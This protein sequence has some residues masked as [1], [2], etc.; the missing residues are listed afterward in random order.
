MHDDLL[1]AVDRAVARGCADPDRI[2]VY[3]GSYGGSYGGYAA[4]NPRW[5]GTPPSTAG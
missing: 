4:L 3:G 2:G 5:R 1:D